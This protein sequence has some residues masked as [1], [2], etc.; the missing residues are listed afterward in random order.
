M[1]L[2]YDH[3]LFSST[4]YDAITNEICKKTGKF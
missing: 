3:K 4:D 1:T 2:D